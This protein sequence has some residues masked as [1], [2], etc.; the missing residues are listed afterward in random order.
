MHFRE[1]FLKVAI[2]CNLFCNFFLQCSFLQFFCN[3]FFSTSPAGGGKKMHFRENFL[4]VGI[5]CNCFLVFFLVHLGKTALGPEKKERHIDQGGCLPAR[6]LFVC[7]PL[8]GLPACPACH[9]EISIFGAFPDALWLLG[10][11][12]GH[13][14]F[15][16]LWGKMWYTFPRFSRLFLHFFVFGPFSTFLSGSL[17]P[18]HY[19][20]GVL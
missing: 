16:W 3:F 1:N 17:A 7:R 2:Y 12:L 15:F 4:E 10:V 6:F 9:S 11:C 13:R 5:Y 19:L 18:E 14:C 8:G 20:L